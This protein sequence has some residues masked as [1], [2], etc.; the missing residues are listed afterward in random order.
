MYS[1]YLKNMGVQSTLVLTLLRDG[2]L[3]GLISCMHHQSPKHVAYEARTA[4]EFLA[5]LLSLAMASKEELQDR[6]YA[7]RL[8]DLQATMMEHMLRHVNFQEGLL[9]HEMNLLSY[10]GAIGAVVAVDGHLHTLGRTPDDDQLRS[11]C[12]WLGERM[13]QEPYATDRLSA[14]Y[15]AGAAF[16]AQASGLLALRLFAHKPHFI[17]WFLPE[18]AKTVDWAGDPRKP[19]DV[20]RVNGEDRLTPR[21]SF[22]LWKE[23]VRGTSRP[24]KP[25]ELTAAG[26]L[27]RSIVEVVLRKAEELAKANED[28]TR[29][30]VELDAFAYIASHDLKEPLRGIHNYARFV[31]EDYEDKLDEEGKYK[32]Q[33]MMKLTERMDDLIN[34]LLLYSRRSR[35]EL[36]AEPTPLLELVRRV[37]QSLTPRLNELAVTIRVVD[38]MPTLLVNPVMFQEVFANLI[39]NAMKYNDKP[40]KWIEIGVVDQSSGS[41]QAARAAANGFTV[42]CV[43]DNGIG[44]PANRL[45]QIFEIFRRLHARD[46]YGGGTGVG[47]TIAKKIVE[48]HGGRLWVESEPGIGSTF[49]IALPT[50]E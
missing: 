12:A 32:L 46:A 11:L 8:K 10:F 50:Q 16:A 40:D 1:G 37:V 21:S 25:V 31:L 39:T 33:T 15:P 49:Y 28:L 17:L 43:K 42:I 5:H 9:R 48:R 35:E 41:E 7:G 38:R 44:I 4:A 26:D 14:V 27:R 23:S 30:N 6:D 19:V 22:A 34:G 3:W 13:G 18:V 2:K 47:L 36:E 45:E 29:S 24:W 20:S